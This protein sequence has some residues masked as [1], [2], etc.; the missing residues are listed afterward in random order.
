MTKEVGGLGT[1][2]QRELQK[3]VNSEA[4]EHWWREKKKTGSRNWG[5]GNRETAKKEV[6][7]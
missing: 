5:G 3:N 4:N 2:A 1:S 7:K 6:Y